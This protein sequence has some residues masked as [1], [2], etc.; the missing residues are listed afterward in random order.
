MKKISLI[1]FLIITPVYALGYNDWMSNID[2]SCSATIK[3]KITGSFSKYG[4]WFDTAVSMDMWADNMRSEKPEEYCYIDYGQSSSK[5]NQVKLLQ[6]VAYI[7]NNWDWF[8]RCKPVVN[9]L[10]QQEANNRKK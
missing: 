6:C 4:F 3:G 8:R 10:S 9:M 5:P 1:L 2:S 7:K